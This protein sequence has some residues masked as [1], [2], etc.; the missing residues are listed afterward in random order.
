MK[1][2][3]STSITDVVLASDTGKLNWFQDLRN[4]S[5][6]DLIEKYA[7][8]EA[9]VETV[10][11]PLLVLDEDLRVNSANKSFFD[12]FQVTQKETYGKHVYD[13]NGG[14]WNIPEL[15]QLLEEI[16]P[17]NSHFNDFEVTHNFSRLGK[18]V[19]LLNARRIVLEENKTQLIFLAIEDITKKKS[20]ELQKDEFISS[21]SH[22]LKT[23]LTVMKSNIWMAK[24]LL[25]KKVNKEESEI[26][27]KINL[28]T[29]KLT[30]M[31]NELLL[32]SRFESSE[33][34]LQRTK[35]DLDALIN[36]VITYYRET[37]P[38]FSFVRK[39]KIKTKVSCEENR[40]EQVL[41]NLMTNAIKYSGDS[42]KIIV[43][44]KMKNGEA[45]VGVQ[46][47]GIGI[48]KKDQPHVFE[49]LF[50]SKVDEL[51]DIQGFGLGLYISSNII[52]LH[53]GK[54]W[55]K[56]TKGKGSTFYISLPAG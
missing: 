21:V 51:D 14:E 42:K 8:A 32:L 10:R 33:G 20:L 53:D 49:R 56:S 48:Q 15:K 35:I 26:L 38:K 1:S 24:N 52:N 9:I 28:H 30:E 22:E 2:K 36:K 16:L 5:I 4:L 47:F 37:Y 6:G 3:K 41:I 25:E 7:Y 34:K 43:H 44:A 13:L 40:I 39:G 29:D 18:R 19:M 46:D 31:I 23:P 54:I 45:V 11:E 27:E 12:T 17:K 50:R 55:M